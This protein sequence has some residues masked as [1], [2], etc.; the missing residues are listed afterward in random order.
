M[1]ER[2]S[3]EMTQDEQDRF[4]KL[5]WDNSDMAIKLIRMENDEEKMSS[6]L[7]IYNTVA[8]TSVRSRSTSAEGT[9]ASTCSTERE[10]IMP[11]HPPPRLP[12][13]T[14]PK[15]PPPRL[16][17]TGKTIPPSDAE[18]AAFHQKRADIS[19]SKTE[20]FRIDTPRASP[21]EAERPRQAPEGEHRHG[22]IRRRQLQY[23]SPMP[24]PADKYDM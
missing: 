17:R 4:M 9:V 19:K 7:T 14:D 16:S 2:N 13:P 23:P 10:W 22:D 8:P 1:P 11:K 12:K 15:P 18:W 5:C 3:K 6:M 20:H 21:R 24:S